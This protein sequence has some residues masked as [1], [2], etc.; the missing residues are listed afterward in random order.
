MKNQ[1]IMVDSFFLNSECILDRSI[2]KERFQIQLAACSMITYSTM[3]SL[4]D[5]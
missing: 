1:K 4:V 5:G 2:T 3:S